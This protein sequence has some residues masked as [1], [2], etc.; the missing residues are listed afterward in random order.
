M[1]ALLA[2]L[3]VSL[4]TQLALSARQYDGEPAAAAR[5]PACGAEEALKFRATVARCRILREEVSLSWPARLPWGRACGACI[6]FGLED[7][8]SGAPTSRLPSAASTTRLA[9]L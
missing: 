7:A 4:G 2:A 5:M 3:L 6:G 8:L 9:L 1:R